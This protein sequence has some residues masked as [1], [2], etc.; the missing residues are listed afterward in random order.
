MIETI[1]DEQYEREAE[2]R[3]TRFLEGLDNIMFVK[4]TDSVSG[5]TEELNPSVEDREATIYINGET[6]GSLAGG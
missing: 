5:E 4:S 2:I 3:L 1:S 6:E